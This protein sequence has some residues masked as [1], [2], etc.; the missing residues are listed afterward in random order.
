MNDIMPMNRPGLKTQYNSQTSTILGGIVGAA[1]GS[2]FGGGS[3][4]DWATASGALLGGSIGRDYE[5]KRRSRQI[6]AQEICST[7][8]VRTTEVVID[9]YNVIYE[10]ANKI[11]S[12]TMS[13][14]PGAT[15]SV[16]VGV[17]PN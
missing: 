3:G 8:N 7:V 9:H 14:Q 16:S 4:K 11:Y 10:Y 12:T 17:V 15:I 5:R 1:V 2:Q 13:H 6:L